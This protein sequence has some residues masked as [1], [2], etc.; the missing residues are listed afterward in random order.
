MCV[1][2]YNIMLQ[3]LWAANIL[4]ISRNRHSR[5]YYKIY[6]VNL[7]QS[8]LT[9]VPLECVINWTIYITLYIYMHI[10]DAFIDWN[11]RRNSKK[12]TT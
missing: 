4:F 7:S 3:C 11:F 8:L 10:Y 1:L 5:K 6:K 2:Q 12:L 9:F